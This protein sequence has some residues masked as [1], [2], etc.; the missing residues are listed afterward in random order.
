MQQQ[1]KLK[2]LLLHQ[3]YFHIFHDHKGCSLSG[4]WLE[5]LTEINAIMAAIRSIIEWMASESILTE[6]L[7]IPAINLIIIKKTFENIESLAV[8]TFLF[9]VKLYYLNKNR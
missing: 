6:P 5:I 2:S 7:N 3:K 1:L 4:G 8:F 9:K